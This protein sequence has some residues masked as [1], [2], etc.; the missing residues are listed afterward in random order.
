MMKF[1]NRKG[2]TFVEI[3][4]VVAIIGLLAAVAIP[5]FANARVMSARNACRANLRQMQ[6]A[7]VAYQVDTGLDPASADIT[8]NYIRTWPREP[9]NGTYSIAGTGANCAVTCSNNGSPDFHTI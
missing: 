6:G 8:V 4:I 1:R 7:I 5:N 9:F 3:M 2:F